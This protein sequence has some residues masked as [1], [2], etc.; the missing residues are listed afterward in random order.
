MK[1]KKNNI[2]KLYSFQLKQRDDFGRTPDL[3]EKK[4]IS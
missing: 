2:C 1:H 4:E 3:K